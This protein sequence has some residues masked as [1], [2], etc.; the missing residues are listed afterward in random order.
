MRLILERVNL[1]KCFP[2][3]VQ[4]RPIL[5]SKIQGKSNAATKQVQN[6]AKAGPKQASHLNPKQSIY[7][8][9]Q[10]KSLDHFHSPFTSSRSTKNITLPHPC[11]STFFASPVLLRIR[12][13][14]RRVASTEF[15]SF[16]SA[17]DVSANS[18]SAIIS[19]LDTSPSNSLASMRPHQ[20]KFA[21][22]KRF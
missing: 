8:H 17:T 3:H 15:G 1:K 18:T 4:S 6:I 13:L 19:F 11:V 21:I 20:L 22:T 10:K 9:N 14:P 12:F 7:N 5:L 16:L 2:Y